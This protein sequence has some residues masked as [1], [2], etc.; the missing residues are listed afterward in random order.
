MHWP[1]LQHSFSNLVNWSMLE[2]MPGNNSLL[3]IL[4]F[5]GFDLKVQWLHSWLWPLQLW[6]EPLLGLTIVQSPLLLLALTTSNKRLPPSF[7]RMQ[8]ILTSLD[9]TNS[10]S[11]HWRQTFPGSENQTALYDPTL[12]LW[13]NFFQTFTKI[14]TSISV[15]PT[16]GWRD[17]CW[18][19]GSNDNNLARY[20]HNS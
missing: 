3:S 19:I 8:C 11:S 15:L 14:K 18:N 2:D 4:Q 5:S 17:N 6:P 20:C 9:Q 10:P 7:D 13:T 1:L 12:R 16:G